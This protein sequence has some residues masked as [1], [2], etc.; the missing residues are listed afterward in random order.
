VEVGFA[1]DVLQDVELGRIMAVEKE[2]DAMGVRG[3]VEMT[4]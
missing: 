4:G 2:D 3:M 1:F